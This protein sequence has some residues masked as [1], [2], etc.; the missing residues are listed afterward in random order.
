[1]GAIETLTKILIMKFRDLGLRPTWASSAAQRVVEMIG[2]G[3]KLEEAI[4]IVYKEL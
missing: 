2:E 1:M 4:S 3:Y